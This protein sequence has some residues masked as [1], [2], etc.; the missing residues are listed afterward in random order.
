MFSM[1]PPMPKAAIAREPQPDTSFMKIIRPMDALRKVMVDGN[2]P[3]RISF[4]KENYREND[5]EDSQG[6]RTDH[7]DEYHINDT[8]PGLK[9]HGHDHGQRKANDMCSKTSGQEILLGGFLH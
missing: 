4:K 7:P 9:Q 6:L 1:R 3:L 5:A 2:P 8:E